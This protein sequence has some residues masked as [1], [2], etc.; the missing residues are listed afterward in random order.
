VTQPIRGAKKEGL[1]GFVKGLGKGVGGFLIKPAAAGMAIP[2]YAFQGVY[3]EVQKHFG[4]GTHSYILA[5][6]YAQ[7]HEDFVTSTQ[8]Q[9]SEVLERWH[10]REREPPSL[11]ARW[12]SAQEWWK[13]G[14]L[15]TVEA[16]RRGSTPAYAPS[17]GQPVE[18]DAGIASPGSG[19]S[20]EASGVPTAVYELP[21]SGQM[22]GVVSRD[23]YQSPGQIT[24]VIGGRQSSPG[25]QS[26]GVVSR[27]TSSE[28]RP[29][30]PP[31]RP[32]EL[33]VEGDTSSNTNA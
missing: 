21:E 16:D 23:Q 1:T 27:D 33:P 11:M 15:P 31:R 2:A 7:G 13:T 26:L 12:Q 32:S 20:Y 17:V 29:D 24:G 8:E 10:T 22:S 25:V 4:S 5:A 18:L 30:L 28:A 3:E 6:R 9:R 19:P 14:K